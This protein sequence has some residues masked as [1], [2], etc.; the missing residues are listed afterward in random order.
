[1]LLATRAYSPAAAATHCAPCSRGYLR[2][3]MEIQHHSLPLPTRRAGQSAE[4]LTYQ[5]SMDRTGSG[6]R[7]AVLQ[8]MYTLTASAPADREWSA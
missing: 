3:P 7:M 1:M 6:R 5:H 8:Y 2:I 4:K